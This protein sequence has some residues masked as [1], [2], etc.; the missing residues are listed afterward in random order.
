MQR[1]RPPPAAETGRSCWGRGQQDASDSAADAGSRN[2]VTVSAVSYT[3]LRE[4]LYHAGFENDS[5]V[6]IKWVESEDLPD[7]AACRE[8]FADVDGIIVPGGFGRCA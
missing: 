7:Q 5:Q 3:H 6:E 8:A 2:P 4:S 1:S